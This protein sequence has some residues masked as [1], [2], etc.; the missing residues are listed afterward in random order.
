MNLAMAQLPTSVKQLSSSH[1]ADQNQVMLHN[2][3]FLPENIS[4]AGTSIFPSGNNTS[5]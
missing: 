4:V 1:S 3:H 5:E 2:I